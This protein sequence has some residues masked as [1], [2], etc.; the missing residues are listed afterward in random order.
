MVYRPSEIENTHAALYAGSPQDGCGK[1]EH[2]IT[3]SP[4]GLASISE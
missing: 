1:V 3:R 4:N 2:G